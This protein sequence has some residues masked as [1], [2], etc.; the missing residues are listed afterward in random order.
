MARRVFGVEMAAGRLVVVEASRRTVRAAH[1]LALPEPAPDG[2]SPAALL[3]Q[4]GLRRG[5]LHLVAWDSEQVHQLLTLPP[6]SAGERA[7]YLRRELTRDGGPRAIGAEVVRRVT[8]GAPKDEVLAVAAPGEAVDRLLAPFRAT[9]GTPRLVTTGPLALVAAARALVPD[10]DAQPTVLAHLG[11]SGLTV[12]VVASGRLT[13]ARQIPRLAAPGLDPLEWAGTEI[14]RSVRHYA[15]TSKGQTAA[16]V[17]FATRV[18]AMERL[19]CESGQLEQRLGLPIVNLNE[20]FRA[21]LP[22]GV[23]EQAGPAAGA[24][25]LAF[26]AATLAPRR[27]ANLLP[28]RML[29]EQRSRAVTRRA[30]AAGLLLTLALAAAYGGA[31][32]DVQRVRAELAR[33]RLLRQA[34]EARARD[35][36]TIQT[37]R[38]RTADRV[39]L[40]LEDPLAQ[41]PVAEALREVSRLAPDGLRLHVLSVSRGDRGLAITLSGIVAEGDLAAAQRDF[42]RLYF[43]LRDSPLFYDVTFVKRPAVAPSAAPGVAAQPASAAAGQFA[44]DVGLRL[45]QVR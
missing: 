30:V 23:E 37:Q 38:Q 8:D 11:F 45:K 34:N 36:A 33:T 27:A 35:V 16:R 19:F 14:Q 15:M 7:L 2:F 44:F 1:I 12:V 25:L 31:T 3:E 9:R 21:L 40:L 20:L 24:L 13:L 42:N 17:V 5:D 32:R 41:P 28:P 6:M 43:G 29:A 26:G 18:A 22:D 10:L 39:R 4:A